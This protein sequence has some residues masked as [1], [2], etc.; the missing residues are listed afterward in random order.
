MFSLASLIWLGAFL[1]SLV[2]IVGVSSAALLF[3]LAVI[4][5]CPGIYLVKGGPLTILVAWPLWLLFS[6]ALV[7]SFNSPRFSRGLSKGVVFT[8]TGTDVCGSAV[9]SLASL[10]L[11]VAVLFS[12]AHIDVISPAAL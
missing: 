3:S 4:A 2:Y 12:L 5:T 7:I 6:L 9:F 1:F 8:G 11:W 10:I